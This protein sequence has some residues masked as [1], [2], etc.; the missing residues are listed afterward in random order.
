MSKL[1]IGMIPLVTNED[2]A[3]RLRSIQTELTVGNMI[4]KQNDVKSW[5]NEM[6]TFVQIL[7]EA[8]QKLNVRPDNH[9]HI[10]HKKYAGFVIVF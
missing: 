4:D 2:I 1:K 9:I 8:C 3:S 7:I 5:I 10:T 6:H